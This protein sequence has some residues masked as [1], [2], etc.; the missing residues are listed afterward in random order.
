[1]TKLRVAF[2]QRR[3]HAK[4]LVNFRGWIRVYQPQDGGQRKSHPRQRYFRD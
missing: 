1:M 4:N 2:A 3:E